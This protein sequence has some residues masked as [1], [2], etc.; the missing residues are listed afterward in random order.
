MN[1]SR[2][3]INPEQFLDVNQLEPP[4]PMERILSAIDALAQGF[5]LRIWI[6][7]EP[8]PLYDILGREDFSHTIRPGQHSAFE[9]FI[10]H[11]QD[12]I[13]RNFVQDILQGNSS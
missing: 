5:Y 3:S 6:H 12:E 11:S 7:R 9:L 4:E 8:F 2:G 10:W 1:F 13:A